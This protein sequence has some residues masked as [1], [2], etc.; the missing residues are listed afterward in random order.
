MNRAI[1][2]IL[3]LSFLIGCAVE[4]DPQQRGA[5][6]MILIE[7]KRLI[8]RT[9]TADDWK[10]FH[11]LSIDWKASPGPAF[12]KWP[13][14]EEA[15]KGSVE[16]MSTEARWYALCLR[17]P[18]KVIGLLGLNGLDKEGRFD[19]GH[20][21][22]TKYQDNDIDKEGLCAMVDYVFENKNVETVVTNNASEHTEQLAPL[23]SL[24]FKVVDQYNPGTLILTKAEWEQQQSDK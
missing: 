19:L 6:P 5:A 21:I 12:D 24:G 4:P 14:S 23:E 7:T 15:A 9:F 2:I 20:V 3:L 16:H 18:A 11:E 13:T 17:E 10:D 1:Q 22:L 8:I